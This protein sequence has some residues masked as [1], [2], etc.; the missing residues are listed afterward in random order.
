MT[1]TINVANNI[2]SYTEI[3][4]GT[5]HNPSPQSTTLRV[6]PQK[7]PLLKIWMPLTK[8]SEGK[9]YGIISD[10]SIDRDGEVISDSLIKEWAKNSTLP[11]LANHINKMENWIGGWTDFKVIEKNGHTA[12]MASPVFFSKEANP[13]A[14]QIQKQIEEAI[15]MGL[16]AGIS[17]GAIPTENIEKEVGG[18]KRKVY[19]KAELVEATFVPIQSNRNATFGHLAK[20][21]DITFEEKQEKEETMETETKEIKETPIQEAPENPLKK[22]MDVIKQENEKLKKELENELKKAVLPVQK[23]VEEEDEEEK[24]VKITIEKMLLKCK[25]KTRGK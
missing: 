24:N 13:L 25:G 6:S 21:F 2:D 14:A 22:E 11:A 20:E 18:K 10:N 3:P 19:T 1:D 12:L 9:Y 16:G 15:S 23:I 5:N 4:K 8:S 7:E 17:I